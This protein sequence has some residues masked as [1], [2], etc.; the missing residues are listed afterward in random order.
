[1]AIDQSRSS[2]GDYVTL[3][4]GTTYE[5]KL[6]GSPGPALLGLG[7][8]EPGGGFR[9]GHY[10]TYGGDCPADL[11]LFPGD[12]YASLKGATKDGKMIGSVARVPQSITSGRLTQDTVK[13]VFQESNQENVNYIYWSL[14]TPQ[15]RDYCEGRAMGS[16][17]VALSRRDFLSYPIP[18][19][20]DIRR[21]IVCLLHKI[22][23]HIEVNRQM[24]ETLEAVA[25][26]IF[27][28][29]FVDFGPTRA[30]A[31]GHA[32]Y[33][34][35]DIW[36]LFPHRLDDDG[37]PE[38][39]VWKNLIQLTEVI[40]RGV[41]PS[42]VEDGGVLVLNQKCIRDRRI[43]V[44]KARRHDPSKKSIASRALR[45]GDI[46]VNSTGVGTLGRVAQVWQLPEMETVIDSHITVV[47]PNHAH[48]SPFY[49]GFNLIGRESEI[50]SLG[51]GSTGQ[52]ELGRARLGALTVLLP[53]S[54]IQSAF[55]QIVRPIVARIV[56]IDGQSRTLEKTRD[57]LLPKLMSGEICVRE[58]ETLVAAAQ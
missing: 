35:P 17:V 57:L 39:W 11:M 42:Y 32:P 56:H 1:M 8:I 10:K 6:V 55:D 50:E 34:T 45:D 26:A 16:A 31:E 22:E 7:S 13:L 2:V 3:V 48:S 19:L 14:R 52:T 36:P 27:K 15:Y 49:L 58:A 47:R 40:Q 20:T 38:G 9:I 41:S 53:P 44:T 51:E 37:K 46:L 24:N 30:K 4:R 12:L 33:L 43:D 25:R 18:P 21:C 23:A 54:A 5:G 28:D 29:W